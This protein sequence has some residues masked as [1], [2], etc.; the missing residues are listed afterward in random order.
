MFAIEANKTSIEKKFFEETAFMLATRF[1]KGS[2][3]LIDIAEMKADATLGILEESRM[4]DL[5]TEIDGNKALD[6][7][8]HII[9]MNKNLLKRAF[10]YYSAGPG[11]GSATSMS[12]QEFR[13]CVRDI[14]I[15]DKNINTTNLD[16][17]FIRVNQGSDNDPSQDDSERELSPLEF[18]EALVRISALKFQKSVT[19]AEKLNMLIQ[20]HIL[21]Y[22]SL[23]DNTRFRREIATQF[24]IKIFEDF[25]DPLRKIFDYYCGYNFF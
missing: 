22:A 2:T 18:I 11:G 4:K 24:V 10:K 19:I 6:D 17:I 9:N 8:Q 3:E 5:F 21:K 7:L 13:K 25:E 23:T 20:D 16:L 12:G 15:M 1:R 14:K